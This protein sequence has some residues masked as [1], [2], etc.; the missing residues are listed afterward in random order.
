MWGQS[1]QM[2]SNTKLI[3][4]ALASSE[5]SGE[6][7]KQQGT[8]HKHIQTVLYETKHNIQNISQHAESN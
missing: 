6:T 5:G 2:S 1:N 4:F 3:P 8:H 7:A